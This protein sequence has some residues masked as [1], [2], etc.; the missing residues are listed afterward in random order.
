[1][2]PLLVVKV[3]GVALLTF[4]LC[5]YMQMPWGIVTGAAIAMIVLP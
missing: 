2:S 1:M 4:V 3:V 5:H